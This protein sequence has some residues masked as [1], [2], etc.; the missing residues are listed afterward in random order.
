[1]GCL[2][3]V[4]SP[5]DGGGKVRVKHAAVYKVIPFLQY[6]PSREGGYG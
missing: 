6:L 3:K 1:M 2:I 5:F 4:P